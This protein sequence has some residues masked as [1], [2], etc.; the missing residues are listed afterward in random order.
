MNLIYLVIGWVCGAGGM[1]YYFHTSRLIRSQSEWR[2]AQGT[3]LLDEQPKGDLK[4]FAM[5][6][7]SENREYILGFNHALILIEEV[8]K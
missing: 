6:P 7:D 1:W 3:C 5:K 4:R 8:M 2:L